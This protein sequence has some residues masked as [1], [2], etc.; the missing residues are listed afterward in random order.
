MTTKR[1]LQLYNV[2]LSEQL[3]TAH[4]KPI[5]AIQ[6]SESSTVLTPPRYPLGSVG[7]HRAPEEVNIL[8]SK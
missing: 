5:F 1:Q 6:F 7:V 3:R 8:A 2:P 4:L